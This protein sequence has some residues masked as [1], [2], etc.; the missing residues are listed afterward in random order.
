LAKG[1]ERIRDL[2]VVGALFPFGQFFN[3]TISFMS[4]QSGFSILMKGLG[5]AGKQKTYGDLFVEAA[6]GWT[7]G[8]G[9]YHYYQKD[10]DDGLKF[11]ERRDSEGQIVSQQYDFP[12]NIYRAIAWSIGYARRGEQP[13]ANFLQ[14]AIEASGVTAFRGL[15]EGLD[16][17]TNVWINASKNIEEGDPALGQAT[18]DLINASVDMWVGGFARPLEPI[19]AAV[20]MARGED[21]T[22]PDRYT[23]TTD[24]SW[25]GTIAPSARSLRYVDQMAAVLLGDEL[26]EEFRSPVDNRKPSVQ[27]SKFFGY[28]DV[29]RKSTIETMMDEAGY[30]SWQ[31]TEY[32]DD[33]VAKRVANSVVFPILETMAIEMKE[34]T[35]WDKLTSREKKIIVEELVRQ[36]K[37]EAK[38]ILKGSE[39]N[40][41]TRTERIWKLHSASSKRDVKKIRE[42]FFENKE[43]G[44]LSLEE[45]ETVELLLSLDDVVKEA[46]L[47][48]V[49]A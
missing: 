30:S 18:R 32:I 9:L 8:I 46:L 21:Y 42:K 24:T 3:N 17:F 7:M 28:R 23:D 34:S 45:L 14:E 2:P 22:V 25:L 47:E 33:P 10:I 35:K 12:E 37:T 15:T 31:A 41:Y 6:A 19:N 16:S 11:N 43:L 40:E 29:D 20:G 36:S 48:D 26:N 5:V 49:M 1:I 13:P 39:D 44:S 4:G 38:K 27:L